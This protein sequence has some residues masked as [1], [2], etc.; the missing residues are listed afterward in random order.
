MSSLDLPIEKQKEIAKEFGMS[1]ADW[2]EYIKESNAKTDA[3]VESLISSP[4]TN[5]LSAEQKQNWQE[6]VDSGNPR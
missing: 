5:K 6:K 4:T 1:H 2:V 3:F